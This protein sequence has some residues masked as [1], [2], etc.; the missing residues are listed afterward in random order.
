MSKLTRM[1]RRALPA[2]IATALVFST[3]ANANDFELDRTFSGIWDMVDHQSQGVVLNISKGPEGEKIGSMMWFTYGD[4]MET[5]WYLAVGPVDGNEIIMKLYNSSGV[6]FLQEIVEEGEGEQV[7]P[8]EQ[9]G[10]VVVS[11]RNCNQGMLG[12]DTPEDVLGTGEIGLKRL[13][14]IYN[15]ALTRHRAPVRR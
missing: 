2:C 10:E 7:N 11:F 5:A 14:S 4:D 15:Y 8:L 3:A 9:I 13:T 12:F 1:S 6:G